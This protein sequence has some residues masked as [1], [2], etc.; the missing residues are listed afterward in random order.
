MSSSIRL[1]L[2]NNKTPTND[3]KEEVLTKRAIGVGKDSNKSGKNTWKGGKNILKN[4]PTNKILKPINISLFI[5]EANRDFISLKL[6][7]YE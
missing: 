1:K 6:I 2:Y 4:I 7:K 3:T 5:C